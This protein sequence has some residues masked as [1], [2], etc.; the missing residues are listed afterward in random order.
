MSINNIPVLLWTHH[1]INTTGP[2]S[3]FWKAFHSVWHGLGDGTLGSEWAQH[4]DFLFVVRSLIPPLLSSKPNAPWQQ[5]RALTVLGR[6]CCALHNLFHSLAPTTQSGG[7]AARS[8]FLAHCM[9]CCCRISILPPSLS[10]HTQN[11]TMCL[12]R[13]SIFL[14]QIKFSDLKFLYFSG[15]DFSIS[16][17]GDGLTI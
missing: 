12:S 9:L 15:L 8:P 6:A 13:C 2:I 7:L 14:T 3:R 1:S 16:W 5:A 4:I 11:F 17:L 10:P